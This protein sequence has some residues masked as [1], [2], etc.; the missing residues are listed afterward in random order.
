MSGGFEWFK[1]DREGS[2]KA[3]MI[4][5][6]CMIALCVIGIICPRL[7]ERTQNQPEHQQN[8]VDTSQ[9]KVYNDSIPYSRQ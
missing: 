1:N 8:K 7:F 5:M 9:H 6:L 3:M 4:F 2:N